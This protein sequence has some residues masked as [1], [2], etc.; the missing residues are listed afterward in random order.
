[1]PGFLCALAAFDTER[2]FT[3]HASNMIGQNRDTMLAET[4]RRAKVD[5]APEISTEQRVSA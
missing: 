1:M 3:L 2:M 5:A 4:P